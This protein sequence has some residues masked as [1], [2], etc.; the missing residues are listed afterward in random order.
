MFVDAAIGQVHEYILDVFSFKA[1]LATAEP[2]D[3]FFINVNLKWRDW[4]YQNID[5]EVPLVAVD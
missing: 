5:A 1:K 2:D 3:S 4:S